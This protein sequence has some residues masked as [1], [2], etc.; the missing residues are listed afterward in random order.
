M[1]YKGKGCD[2]CG[3]T[4][5]KGRTGVH[6][7]LIMTGELRALVYKGS[8][9]ARNEK[10]GHARRDADTDSRWHVESIKRG[11][12]YLSDTHYQ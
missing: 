7:L 3:D 2:E 9:C 11:Y 12:G 5:Y 6:E 4:G 8:I 1:L 10:P